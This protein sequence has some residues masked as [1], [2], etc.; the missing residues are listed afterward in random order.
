MLADVGVVPVFDTSAYSRGIGRRIYAPTISD[1]FL[2]DKQVNETDSSFLYGYEI[3]TKLG[4]NYIKLCSFRRLLKG[5]DGYDAEPI[6]DTIINRAQSF[7][8]CLDSQPK[9]FPTGRGSIQA[10]YYLDDENHVEIE[11]FND[12]YSVYKISQGNEIE[13]KVSLRESIRIMNSFYN[14]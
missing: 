9:V 11:I 14:G 3:F 10:E 13:K 8:L 6:P 4:E 12:H 5:W 1:I 7:L 2:N